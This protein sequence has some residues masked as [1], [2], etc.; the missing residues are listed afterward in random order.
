MHSVCSQ[1]CPDFES[2]L[3]LLIHKVINSFRNMNH[4]NNLS[5]SESFQAF[6][7][8]CFQRLFRISRT[9]H[10]T[11]VC[12]AR[13]QAVMLVGPQ[14][15]LPPPVNG[16]KRLWFGH[17]ILH[18]TLSKTDLLGSLEGREGGADGNRPKK[19]WAAWRAGREVQIET[20]RRKAEQRTPR[21]GRG[22]NM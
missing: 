7:V 16:R 14:K 4:M 10:R 6:E 21:T 12:A 8:E 9:E 20:D 19:S 17:V 18:D 15:P 3:Q 13:P 1:P 11:N 5:E 2:E 22:G